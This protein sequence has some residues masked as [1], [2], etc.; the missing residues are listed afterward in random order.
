MKPLAIDLFCGAGG[1]TRGI[2]DA[3]FH[4]TGV[5]LEPQPR[6]C[7]D[8]FVQ[9][10]ALRFLVLNFDKFLVKSDLIWASPPCQAHTALK[11]MHNAKRHEDLIG[12]TREALIRLGKP[13]VIENVVGAPLIDAFV[14]RGDMFDLG[15]PGICRLVR[16]RLFETSFPVELPEPRPQQ[17][18]PVIGVYGGHYRNRRRKA[19]L[20]REAKDFTAAEGRQAMG[21]DWMTG[22]E[23]SQ[24]IPPA[25]SKWIAEQWL[26][27]R[28]DG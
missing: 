6:Y 25:Y 19:G 5:D 14:L 8:I 16:E 10:D 26:A 22:N 23:L 20:D 2:Q 17:D 18:L 11:T 21:I 9:Y 7:G 15:V 28:P 13:Y 24:A 3:G 12:R 1:A 27:S 4:V